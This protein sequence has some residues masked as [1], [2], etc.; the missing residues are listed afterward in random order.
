VGGDSEGDQITGSTATTEFD[1][2]MAIGFG[3]CGGA[4]V[5]IPIGQTL[6]L[7]FEFCPTYAFARAREIRLSYTTGGM[8]TKHRTVYVRSEEDLGSD[9][10]T[11]SYRVGGPMLSLSS[12]AAK[13]GVTWEF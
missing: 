10:A 4:G 5:D 9:D 7:R 12:L 13:A 11:V 3:V 1:F 2:D 6:G 8:V